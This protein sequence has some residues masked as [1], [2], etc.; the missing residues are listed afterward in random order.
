MSLN[1]QQANML[2]ILNR[3]LDREKSYAK[4]PEWV[5][6]I[7]VDGV[8]IT[9]ST[10][11]ETAKPIGLEA[12]ATTANLTP[13]HDYRL[14]ATRA[15]ESSSIIKDF[16]PGGLKAD[17]LQVVAPFGSITGQVHETI[18]RNV[19][20]DTVIIAR[21]GIADKIIKGENAIICLSYFIV[22]NAY[23]TALLSQNDLISLSFR[24]T[25]FE[26]GAQSVDP[27]QGISSGNLATAYHN[28]EDWSSDIIAA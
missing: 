6:G 15:I 26:H 25:Y 18:S 19:L 7:M 16:M 9:V 8:F 3:Y 4:E 1:M 17:Q 28:L 12:F 21:L 11:A 5:M 10:E 20:V 23:I 2:Q 14:G 22:R 27:A 13:I 24:Y